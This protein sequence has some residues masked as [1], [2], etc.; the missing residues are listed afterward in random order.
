VEA[1]AIVNHAKALML[2]QPPAHHLGLQVFRHHVRHTVMTRLVGAMINHR[3]HALALVGPLS[4]A[5]QSC[6]H[7]SSIGLRWLDVLHV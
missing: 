4:P 5:I 3:S 2:S 6:T 7:E 1:R